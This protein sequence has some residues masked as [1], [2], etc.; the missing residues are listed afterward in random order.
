M[1]CYFYL[2]FN[3][4]AGEVVIPL[5]P[6]TM[7]PQFNPDAHRAAPRVAVQNM[8]QGVNIQKSIPIHGGRIISVSGLEWT[9]SQV[10]QVEEYYTSGQEYTATYR[11]TRV[12][13]A[14][15]E[16]PVEIQKFEYKPYV[17]KPSQ[18][19]DW[20]LELI[21]RGKYDTDGVTILP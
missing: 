3:R 2:V 6:R 21:T 1:E 17:N 19:Y 16:W 9:K 11:D 10:E 8:I 13:D 18:K 5:S 4:G 15:E 7:Q 20:T 14:I 12:S